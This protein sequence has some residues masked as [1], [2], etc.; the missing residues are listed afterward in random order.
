MAQDYRDVR[1]ALLR[2]LLSRGADGIW[3]HLE[4]IELPAHKV[5]YHTGE[6]VEHLY[7]L[8]QGLVSRVKILGDGRA[9]EAGALS[10]GVIDVFTLSGF[11]AS[12]CDYVV[13][14]PGSAFRIRSRILQDEVARSDRAS[15]L[16][17]E[18]AQVALGAF[19]QTIACNC[20]HSVQQRCCRWLLTAHDGVPSD[21]FPLTHESLALLLG[22]RRAGIS[23]IASSLQEA[24]LISYRRGLVT[25]IDRRGLED[26]ACECYAMVHRQLERLFAS[27]A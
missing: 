2:S 26:A 19:M 18:Y 13:Q 25:V 15:T 9:V 7:F 5:L 16:L 12:T 22:V 27:P 24:G 17:R 14:L 10:E 4:A 1:N 11:H 21:S 20:L 23:L 8:N 3:D 6:N